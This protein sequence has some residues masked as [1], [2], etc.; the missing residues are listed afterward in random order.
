MNTY[1]FFPNSGK[2]PPPIEGCP[3]SL[4]ALMT[5]CWNKD[6][7]IRPTM[8]EI[9]RKMQFT[10]QFFPTADDPIFPEES[11]VTNFNDEDLETLPSSYAS[12]KE[13][14]TSK[15][16]VDYHQHT[17][18]INDITKTPNN[19]HNHNSS[20]TDHSGI[21]SPRSVISNC[22]N[23]DKPLRVK[24]INQSVSVCVFFKINI[25]KI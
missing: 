18:N 19:H 16:E 8:G 15:S 6:A 4:E 11:S 12:A 20:E 14:I 25:H 24:L 1:I 23:N 21:E 9:V 10:Q 3:E 7:Q 17:G 13:N 5:R 2:R 22:D